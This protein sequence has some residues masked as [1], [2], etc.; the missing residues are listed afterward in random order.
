MSYGLLV[1]NQDNRIQIDENYSNF[2]YLSNGE[3]SATPGATKPTLSQS[4]D[5]L[6]ARA[7]SSG[8]ICIRVGTYWWDAD[9]FPHPTSGIGYFIAREVSGNIS[10]AGSGYGIE[11]HSPTSTAANPDLYFSSGSYERGINIVAAGTFTGTSGSGGPYEVALPSATSTYPDLTKLYCMMNNTFGLDIYFNTGFGD[12]I[13]GEIVVGYRY[14][15]VSGN[16]GRIHV[17]LKEKQ[18]SFTPA[19]VSGQMNYL[20]VEAV[21]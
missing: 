17:C 21:E 11:V 19:V 13:D 3:Q 8:H 5:L 7:K 9:K 6:F 4:S 14:E 1:Q 16:S 18:Y 20:I 2:Y 12:P 15:F 10:P